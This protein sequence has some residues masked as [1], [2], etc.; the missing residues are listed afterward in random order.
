VRL[1]A[2]RFGGRLSLGVRH[3]GEKM[4]VLV[5]LQMIV[6]VLFLFSVA[7]TIQ[8]E[9]V[10]G[11]GASL[12]FSDGTTSKFNTV[13]SAPGYS[14]RKN[15]DS[16]EVY[17]KGE[18]LNVPLS[19]VQEM[20]I[21]KVHHRD[22]CSSS[23]FYGCKE[24]HFDLKLRNGKNFIVVVKNRME[25]I[26]GKKIN[27]LTNEITDLK[28]HWHTRKGKYVN[29]VIFSEDVGQA[30]INPTTKRVWPSYYNYDPETGEKLMWADAE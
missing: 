11:F 30:R 12:Y 8:A 9:E 14:V 7:N 13:T 24:Y 23:V 10:K 28:F 19:D 16:F 6:S 5:R 15:K 18:K 29:K 17:L 21:V 1:S 2:Y 27:P 3:I 25:E 4:K 26:K 20:T 22:G